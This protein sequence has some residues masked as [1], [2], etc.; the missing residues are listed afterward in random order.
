MN[1]DAFLGSTFQQLKHQP[2]TSLGYFDATYRPATGVLAIEIR[3]EIA[4]SNAGLTWTTEIQDTFKTEFTNKIPEYWNDRFV[5]GCT[6]PGWQDVV[7]KPEF[8]LR[9][10]TDRHFSIKAAGTMGTRNTAV[11][12]FGT[13]HDRVASSIDHATAIFGSQAADRMAN[14]EFQLGEIRGALRTPFDIPLGSPSTGGQFS[15]NAMSHLQGFANNVVHAFARTATRPKLKLTALDSRSS[16]A[17]DKVKSILMHFGIQNP[18]ETSRDSMFAA[19]QASGVRVEWAN[20]AEFDQMFPTDA[21][22]VPLFSQAT[23]VHEYGHMLG[24][25][26][27]YN[28][29]CSESVNP[30]VAHMLVRGDTEGNQYLRHNL[31]RDAAS[32]GAIAE[33][34]RVFMELC[35]EAGILPPPFGR[36]NMNVM[37]GGSRFE[38]HHCITA[39]EALCAMTAGT[40]E[41]KEWQIR[42]AS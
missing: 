36:P 40:V 17:A 23:I 41:K 20:L 14:A 37:S 13:G 33:N 21:K 25:P 2:S 27:E 32:G 8:S 5:I 39:W 6:K 42:M 15:F 30:L 31:A 24:L 10:A 38:P 35:G 7:V 34:Q 1:K 29:L 19:E 12:P 16:G 26:D 18:I 28:V 22:S 11:R 4:F 3:Y 9:E